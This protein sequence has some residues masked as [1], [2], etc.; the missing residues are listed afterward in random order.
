MKKTFRCDCS[1]HILEIGYTK[2][3]KRFPNGD[4]FVAIYDVYNEKGDRKLRKPKL[5]ADV[6][7]FNNL[8]KNELNKLLIFLHKL[9]TAEHVKLSE[10]NLRKIS[11]K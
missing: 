2:P 1:G 8:Y 3:T 11:K 6:M 7:I 5:K 10:S 4:M 9:P